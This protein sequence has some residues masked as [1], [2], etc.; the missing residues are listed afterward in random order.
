MY[1]LLAYDRGC[2]ESATCFDGKELAM[3]RAW[4]TMHNLRD[5]VYKLRDPPYNLRPDIA[6][7]VEESFTTRWE[8]VFTDLHYAGALLN[9]FLK[10]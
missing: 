9:P 1:Q 5:H 4:L 6:T 3:D 10:D 2:V 7:T 8:M